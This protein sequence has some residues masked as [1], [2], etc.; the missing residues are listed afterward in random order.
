VRDTP[1]QST[2]AQPGEEVVRAEAGPRKEHAGGCVA[3]PLGAQRAED[4][5]FSQDRLRRIGEFAE[6]RISARSFSG[7]VTLVARHG[8]IVHLEAHGRADLESKRPMRTDAIFRIMSMTKPDVFT[9]ERI[10]RP[11][12]MSDTFFHTESAQPRLA[13]LY[14]NTAEGLVP[15]PVPRS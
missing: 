10:L 3:P 6:R 5:G 7:A 8:R 2:F 13:A 9:R 1:R 12:G 15:R 14:R 4:A 11:L